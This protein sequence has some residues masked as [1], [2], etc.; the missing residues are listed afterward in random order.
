MYVVDVCGVCVVRALDACAG[1]A[2]RAHVVR[3][4]VVVRR[5]RTLP[6]PLRVCL[7]SRFLHPRALAAPARQ[8]REAAQHVPFLLFLFV[9]GRTER[10]AVKRG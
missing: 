6:D 5:V 7:V 2:R 4:G 10:K 3:T 1:I 8:R 9:V